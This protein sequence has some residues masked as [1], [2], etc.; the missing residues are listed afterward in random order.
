MRHR[1]GK[2]VRGARFTN[3]PI[4]DGVELRAG[5]PE[6]PQYIHIGRFEWTDPPGGVPVPRDR[7]QQPA[8]RDETQ[9]EQFRFRHRLSRWKRRTDK[10]KKIA[11]SNTGHATAMSVA[12]SA[13][14]EPPPQL[15][16]PNRSRAAATVDE[17]G[18]HS[19]IVPSHRGMVPGATK[20]LDRKVTGQ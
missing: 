16:F 8:T 9:C 5:D 10:G 11:M 2:R 14:Q 18:F 6:P 17:S 19:A 3:E 20:V 4:G 13:I 15:G 7:R 12:C 1:I